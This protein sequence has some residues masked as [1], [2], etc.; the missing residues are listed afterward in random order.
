MQPPAR[1]PPHPSP[2]VTPH[3]PSNAHTCTYT[4]IHAFTWTLQ[5]HRGQL[6]YASPVKSFPLLPSLTPSL[7]KTP[8]CAHTAPKL[9]ATVCDKGKPVSGLHPSQH[10]LSVSWGKQVLLP[11]CSGRAAWLGQWA[12]GAGRCVGHVPSEL[13]PSPGPAPCGGPGWSAAK[14]A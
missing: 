13:W 11:G 3:F 9:P 8:W 6:P 1:Q 14:Q 4:R 10:P 2:P 12:Q 7:V 5:A